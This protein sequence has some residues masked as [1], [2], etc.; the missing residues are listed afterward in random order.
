MTNFFFQV[1]LL[2]HRVLHAFTEKYMT[3]HVFRAEGDIRQLNLHNPILHSALD[4]GSSELH[5]MA[6]VPSLALRS[7]TFPEQEIRRC[8]PQGC[9][10]LMPPILSPKAS[11][12]GILPCHEDGDTQG[13]L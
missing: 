3:C 4:S 6:E 9:S 2:D 11:V 7:K 1:T 5:L 13:A 12:W 10:P 8:H